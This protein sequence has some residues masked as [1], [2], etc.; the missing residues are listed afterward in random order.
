MRGL[1][2]EVALALR[3]RIKCRSKSIKID[4]Y[5]NGGGFG[6]ERTSLEKTEVREGASLE[7]AWSTASWTGF[8]RG[9]DV[10]PFRAWDEMLVLVA[11]P[12]R[13]EVCGVEVG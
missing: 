5:W 7:I 6:E 12:A 9:E 1:K 3:V 13:K 8:D 10:A 2:G 4:R 11:D